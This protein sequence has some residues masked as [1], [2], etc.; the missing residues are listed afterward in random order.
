MKIAIASDDGK[1]I[2]A[3]TG[4]CRYFVFYDVSEGKAERLEVKE[5]VFTPHMRGQGGQPEPQMLRDGKGPHGT[6]MGGG[7]GHAAL[8]EALE[9]AEVFIAR[10][11]G[12]RLIQAFTSHG[13]R[14]IMTELS[15]VDAAAQ[16]F[17]EGNLESLDKGTCDH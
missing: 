13:I 14:P 2:S 17:A 9:G 3:H 5:N 15:E 8:L 7:G 6:G 1:T 12:P 16:Q 10:G 11:M 4:R